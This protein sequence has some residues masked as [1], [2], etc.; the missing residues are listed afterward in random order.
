M[1]A[2]ID[3]LPQVGRK[4]ME[5]FQRA[6]LETL[7]DIYG[8]K[9]GQPLQLALKQMQEDDPVFRDNDSYW[10]GL[11]TRVQNV[12]ARVRSDEAWPYEPDH[13]VC[14]ITWQLMTDPVLSKYGDT[15]ERSAI[16]KLINDRGVD[17]YCQPLTA[18][19][20]YSNRS[21]QQAIEYYRE[22]EIRFA[23]PVKLFQ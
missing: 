12:I 3:A 13:F 23:I 19:D 11:A 2:R 7:G 9:C 10:K 20:I 14:P 15:Y 17:I 21:L 4:T 16:L 18:E 1:S 5:V 6:G 22:H 8:R